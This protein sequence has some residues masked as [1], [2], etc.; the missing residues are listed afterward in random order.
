MCTHLFVLVT[1]ATKRKRINGEGNKKHTSGSECWVI[2]YAI[3]IG[4]EKGGAYPFNSTQNIVKQQVVREPIG[5]LCVRRGIR[6]PQSQ[7]K[8]KLY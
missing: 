6:K 5:V 1:R 3:T 4:G 2:M 8:D 7:P